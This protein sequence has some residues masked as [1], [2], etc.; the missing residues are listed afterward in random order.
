MEEAVIIF[1]NVTKIYKLYRND[2]ERFMS[3]FSKKKKYK[4]KKAADNIS[5]T[6]N[7]GESVALLGKNGAGKSLSLIHI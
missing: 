1:D 7:K 2:R 4:E 3:L 5:F 6:V